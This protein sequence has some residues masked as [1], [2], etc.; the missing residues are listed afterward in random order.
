MLRFLEE[1]TEISRRNPQITR[2][3]FLGDGLVDVEADIVLGL[4]NIVTS[5]LQKEN[6]GW[7]GDLC[8]AASVAPQA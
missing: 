6:S 4:L 1:G 2:Y 5:S 7:G 3:L 8:V